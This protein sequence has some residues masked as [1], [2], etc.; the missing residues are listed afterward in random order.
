MACEKLA[1]VKSELW[2]TLPFRSH[3]TKLL[4]IRLVF[5]KWVSRTVQPSKE[6]PCKLRSEKL[7]VSIRQLVNF[8]CRNSGSHFPKLMPTSLQLSNS[9]SCK[10]DPSNF[11]REKLQAVI[12]HARSL[13]PV[14]LD[15]ENSQWSKV[16]YEKTL[17]LQSAFAKFSFKKVALLE[18]L[19]I[20][21]LGR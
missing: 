12:L 3:F 2:K 19:S 13:E 17:F 6:A 5:E 9:I 21:I 18:S 8:N 4:F 11:V 1:L 16:Q 15:L 20:I 14:K 7:H 10:R